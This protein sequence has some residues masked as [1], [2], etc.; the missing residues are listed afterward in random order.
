M[1]QVLK[2]VTAASARRKV[3][4]AV[5][6]D[7]LD[8]HFQI[9]MAASVSSFRTLIRTLAAN[10]SPEQLELQAGTLALLRGVP[11]AAPPPPLTSPR[12]VGG[13]AAPS[14]GG[15]AAAAPPAATP[16]AAAPRDAAAAAAAPLAAAPPV[17]MAI[18]AAAAAPPVDPTTPTTPLVDPE[19]THAPA[20]AEADEAGEA[21]AT[22]G[23]GG[24]PAASASRHLTCAGCLDP[25]ASLPC[26]CTAP[27]RLTSDAAGWRVC[28]PW[29]ARVLLTRAEL[30]ALLLP[31]KRKGVYSAADYE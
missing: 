2:R 8:R 17:A 18:D 5:L 15:I 11:A 9:Q 24:E 10:V 31:A 14:P 19:A 12:P 16:P 13:G 21:R 22:L 30:D 23:S 26:T 20:E 3:T 6:K 27:S 7:S 1:N 4:V 25:A 29:D 28:A